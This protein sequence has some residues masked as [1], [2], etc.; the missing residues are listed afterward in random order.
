M[1]VFYKESVAKTL[2]Y[3]ISTIMDY[4]L[5]STTFKLLVAMPCHAM[6]LAVVG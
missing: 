5:S 4:F 1:V 2:Y 6:P 3:I